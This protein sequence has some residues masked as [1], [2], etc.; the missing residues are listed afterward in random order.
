M[1]KI[2]Q[3]NP[4]NIDSYLDSSEKYLAKFFDKP[5]AEND[6]KIQKELKK[7]HLSWPIKYHLSPQRHMLLN[8]YPFR[9]DSSLLEIGAGCGAIT[10]VFVNKLKQIDSNEL[11]PSR[12]QVIYNRFRNVPNLNILTGD[13]NDLKT[14]IQYDY[15]TLIG[16]LEYSGK[17]SKSKEPYLDI[18]RTS[19]K[20]LKK[21]GHLLIAIENKLGLKYIG[22][23][24]E[25]HTGKLFDSLENYPQSE[26]VR[27]FSKSELTKLIISAGFE[28]TDFYYPFPDYKM[29][30]IV[31][32][33]DGLLSIKS[34][35]KS[36]I[37]NTVDF[38][39]EFQNL[40][41]ETVLGQTL[42][43]ENLIDKFAN[44]FLVDAYV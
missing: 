11:S 1:A 26:G 37:L 9:T 7:R 42:S 8:W 36:S 25:D 40:F 33:E 32:S 39:K 10:G 6:E 29:P 2:I 38:S 24:P 4:D 21:D 19:K 13:I 31:F 41:N 14:K 35:T 30:Q 23:A 16:V 18:L 28:K 20:L 27:T 12:A 44:S 22:G 5:E 15:V 17:Y 34:M 3:I 43:N